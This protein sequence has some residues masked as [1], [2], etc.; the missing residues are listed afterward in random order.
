MTAESVKAYDKR[1]DHPLVPLFYT[2]FL[3]HRVGGSL[4][5]DLESLL[6]RAVSLFLYI[7][8]SWS[9]SVEELGIVGEG[10]EP[11]SRA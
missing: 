1:R 7:I 8:C 3:P 6:S 9:A 10:S 5:A 2:H 11:Q 4:S